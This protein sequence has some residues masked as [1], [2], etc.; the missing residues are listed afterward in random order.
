MITKVFR[1]NCVCERCGNAWTT[2]SEQLSKACPGCKSWT[3]NSDVID[4]P[5]IVETPTVETVADLSQK[6]ESLGVSVGIPDEPDEWEGWTEEK[7][8]YSDTTGETIIYRKQLVKPFR[9]QEIRRE[10]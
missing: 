2:R 5:Q 4:T 9:I 3:W 7:E 8:E 10:H 6:L 1:W